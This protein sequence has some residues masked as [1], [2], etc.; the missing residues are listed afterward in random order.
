L[1][2]GYGTLLAVLVA[3][4]VFLGPHADS[5]ASRSVQTSP[6][7]TDSSPLSAE[8]FANENF[9]TCNTDGD[10][11]P[12]CK[13][14][15]PLCP[16]KDLLD[17]LQ[18]HY[19]EPEKT[20]ANSTSG[21]K[22]TKYQVD[23]HWGVPQRENQK[24]LFVI[25]TV[26]DPVHTHLSLFFDRSIKAITKGAQEAGFLFSRTTLPWE[27]GEHPDTPDVKVRIAEQLYQEHKEEFPGLLIF[28]GAKSAEQA[29]TES[30]KNPDPAVIAAGALFVLVVGE[31]PTGGIHKDQFKN[32]LRMIREIR[33]NDPNP[34]ELKPLRI[35]GTTS[36]GSLAS[37]EQI[38]EQE[39][40]ED[41]RTEFPR[42]L[43]HSGT[44]SSWDATEKF[45]TFLVASQ[46]NAEFVTF[47][48]SDS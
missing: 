1:K 29:S 41:T 43:V 42:I 14:C 21:E 48:E 46:K 12:P 27:S 37:L 40:G 18:A 25:A 32:A 8:R 13:N 15:S 5:S 35:L 36:S 24:I 11:K 31:T 9:T 22:L 20:S 10:T 28:R 17:T 47:Q 34:K 16:A 30:S 45:R 26:P 19:G 3:F 6:R 33:G 7:K 23:E 4:S 2:K 44:A 38:M 39:L